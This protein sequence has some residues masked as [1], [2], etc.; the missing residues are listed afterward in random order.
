MPDPCERYLK[1]EHSCEGYVEC[2]LR[3]KGFK[4]VAVDR[5]GYDIAA[6]HPHGMYYYFI[7][8][9]CGPAA[10]LSTFQR[11]FKVAVEVAREE[12]YFPTN[13]EGLELEPKFVTCQ[14]DEEY[15]LIGDPSCKKLLR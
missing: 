8:V 2:V 10:K 11:Y 12:K 5:H 6:Y 1:V 15:R 9:K 14:F 13:E 7:E 3:N 4:I